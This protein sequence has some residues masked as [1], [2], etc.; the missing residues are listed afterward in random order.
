M[1][2]GILLENCVGVELIRNRFHN[3]DQ[4]VV[5]RKVSGLTATRNVSTHGVQP[6]RPPLQSGRVLGIGGFPLHPL[7]VAMWRIY[8]A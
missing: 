1:T 4:P 3:I 7:T 2:V 5:A 6:E 8:R